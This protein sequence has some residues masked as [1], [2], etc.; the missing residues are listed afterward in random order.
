[1]YP[2][3]GEVNPERLKKA[4]KA[5]RF[6]LEIFNADCPKIAI[7]NP[8]PL[9]I[10]NLPKCTQAIQPYQFGHPYS[11]Q[12]LLWLKGLP[13]LESTEILGKYAPY[14]P[15]N[16]SKFAK[17]GVG[18]ST[19]SAHTARVRSLTFPGIAKAMAEQ[20]AGYAYDE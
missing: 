14:C 12:T 2:R 8:V 17:N 9:K 13:L 7:E 3:S 1:M 20:W 18:G 11:K 6:F 5:R 10:V 15:S 4:M 19:G 16:T